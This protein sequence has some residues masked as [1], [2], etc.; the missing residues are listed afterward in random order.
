MS[1][2]GEVEWKSPEQL[3]EFI[4]VK[5]YQVQYSEVADFFKRGRT[6][7]WSFDRDNFNLTVWPFRGPG[8]SPEHAQVDGSASAKGTTGYYH[9][10]RGLES[11]HKTLSKLEKDAIVIALKKYFN[12]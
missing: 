1:D 8:K 11:Y 10:D 4:F 7:Y 2:F 3:V 5:P 9:K 6:V 12:S